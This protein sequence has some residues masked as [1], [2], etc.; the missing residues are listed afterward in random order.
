[1]YVVINADFILLPVVS[2][3]SQSG[4]EELLTMKQKVQI[5]ADETAHSLKK[6][7]YKN[8]SQF[9][10]TAKEISSMI[11]M[12]MYGEIAKKSNIAS[13]KS[14]DSEYVVAFF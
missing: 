11:K 14:L 2:K 4:E 12:Y 5:L 10:E 7:V 3:L 8:Y 9:I 6:N 1:M 13:M